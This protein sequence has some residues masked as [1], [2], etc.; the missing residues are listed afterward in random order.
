MEKLSMKTMDIG[1]QTAGNVKAAQQTADVSGDYDFRKMLQSKNE[2]AQGKQDSKEVS[3]DQ[4]KDTATDKTEATG[5]Q[6]QEV[7]EEQGKTEQTDSSETDTRQAEVMIALQ[8]RERYSYGFTGAVQETEEQIPTDAVAE[9]TDGL[10]EIGA[11]EG[12]QMPETAEQGAVLVQNEEQAQQA[13]MPETGRV[14]TVKQR[15]TAEQPEQMQKTADVKTSEAMHSRNILRRSRRRQRF[16][17]KQSSL[18]GQRW[19]GRRRRQEYTW[20]SRRNCRRR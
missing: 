16:G 10:P 11:E 12:V 14:Q 5:N 20:S 18:Y 7:S 2:D 9:V 15:Q 19:K 6:K 8:I 4:N 13:Q 1:F 17:R 3:K